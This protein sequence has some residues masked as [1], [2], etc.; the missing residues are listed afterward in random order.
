MH[1]THYRD[2]HTLQNLTIFM[3]ISVFEP[4]NPSFLPKCTGN[5]FA[6]HRPICLYA[7]LPVVPLGS[8]AKADCRVSHF[9]SPC[10]FGG[11]TYLH[12]IFLCPS[13]SQSPDHLVQGIDT[14]ATNKERTCGKYCYSCGNALLLARTSHG[15]GVLL[16]LQG[17][18]PG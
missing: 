9:T 4:L 16:C 2:R 14:I 3:D 7:G 12:S 6:F 1:K 11:L 15:F 17:T 18:A 13:S 5:I 8:K 10:S